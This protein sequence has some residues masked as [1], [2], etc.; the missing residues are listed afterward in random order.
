MQGN[1]TS[2][3]IPP[4]A[5]EDGSRHICAFFNGMDEHYRVLRSFIKDGFDRAERVTLGRGALSRGRAQLSTG[6]Q[7]Y[8]P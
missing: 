7:V 8:R 5:L 3:E 1:D 4:N 6:R 2:L